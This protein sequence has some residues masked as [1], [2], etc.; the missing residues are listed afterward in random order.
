MMTMHNGSDLI[1]CRSVALEQ[2]IFDRPS[3]RAAVLAQAFRAQPNFQR[4]GRSDVVVCRLYP[5]HSQ[6][7]FGTRR[8]EVG[9]Q[10]LE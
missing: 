4:A 2:T 6:S 5:G 3:F 9:E 10:T 8:R 7:I 1:A